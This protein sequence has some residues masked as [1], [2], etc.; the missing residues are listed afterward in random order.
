M[1]LHIDTCTLK[2]YSSL[3]T[4]RSIYT[5]CVKYIKT[6]RPQKISFI[7]RPTYVPRSAK[8]PHLV[9]VICLIRLKGNLKY[10]E[11]PL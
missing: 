9:A 1:Y 6:A 2:M 3:K 5:K 11:H 4:Y 7:Y 10:L 8:F